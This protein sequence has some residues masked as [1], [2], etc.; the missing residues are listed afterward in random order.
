MAPP[1]S[2]RDSC[3]EYPMIKVKLSNVSSMCMPLG[4]VVGVLMGAIVSVAS[5]G[6]TLLPKPG[7]NY[8]E[9]AAFNSGHLQGIT[10]NGADA[11][12]WSFTDKLV[13]TDG[14]GNT[15]NVINVIDHHG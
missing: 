11:I 14:A 13:K 1:I 9:T 12:Y 2:N 5:A 10:T 8:V 6:L 15:L 7:Q 4:V 3:C